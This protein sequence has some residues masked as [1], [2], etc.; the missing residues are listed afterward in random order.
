MR[1]VETCATGDGEGHYDRVAY[2]VG[3][4]CGTYFGDC[5]GGFV[6]LFLCSSI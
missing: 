4:D 2:F 3:F 5:A 6:A 1:A